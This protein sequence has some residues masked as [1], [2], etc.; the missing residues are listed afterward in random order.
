MTISC[1]SDP[2]PDASPSSTASR[3]AQPTQQ[4]LPR[5]ATASAASPAPAPLPASKV[6]TMARLAS[7]RSFL[8]HRRQLNPRI[9]ADPRSTHTPASR[10]PSQSF[11]TNNSSSQ[12]T[13]PRPRQAGD[14]AP[15]PSPAAPPPLLRLSASGPGPS[16]PPGGNTS[17]KDTPCS[18]PVS[19]LARTASRR[20][21]SIDVALSNVQAQKQTAPAASADLPTRFDALSTP[22]NTN[23]LSVP[24]FAAPR[25]SASTGS[26]TPMPSPTFRRGLTVAIMT[27]DGEIVAES[28]PVTPRG[29]PDDSEPT[30]QML[31]GHDRKS[32]VPSGMG[33]SG[34]P[35]QREIILCRYYHT[36]GLTCTSSPCRFVHSLEGLSLRGSSLKSGTSPAPSG[37][38]SPVHPQ[39]QVEKRTPSMP[40]SRLRLVSHSGRLSA[41]PAVTISSPDPTR[42]TFARAQDATPLTELQLD[43]DA[44]ATIQSGDPVSLRDAEGKEITGHVFKLSGG[45][46]GAGGKSRTKYKSEYSGC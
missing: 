1:S 40:S 7:G 6:G 18:A 16:G 36:E 17:E 25:Y 11:R 19:R 30:P 21:I 4:G 26:F 39:Q 38:S 33:T 2:P 44:L 14:R 45:G 8:A 37:R 9:P 32:P 5:P 35:R 13:R 43:A 23:L 41:T 24:T 31:N 12:H 46:K 22:P 20:G 27:G 42:G 15:P 34:A 29:F 3:P 10:G 28:A